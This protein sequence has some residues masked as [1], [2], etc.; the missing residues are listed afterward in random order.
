MSPSINCEATN[1]DKVDLGSNEAL[2]KRLKA[3]RG[4]SLQAE[5]LNCI[6]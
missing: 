5:P 3:L 6:S 2:K 1:Q 4:Q